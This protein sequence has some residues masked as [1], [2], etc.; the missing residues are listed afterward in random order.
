MKG[1]PCRAVL[2]GLLCCESK[3]APSSEPVNMPTGDAVTVL[4]P[5][6]T[7]ANGTRLDSDSTAGTAV[8][9][10]D[11]GDIIHAA[12]GDMMPRAAEDDS[13][14]FALDKIVEVHHAGMTRSARCSN[15]EP[16]GEEGKGRG[17]RKEL[18]KAH[19]VHGVWP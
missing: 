2:C 18:L 3:Y 14:P 7:Y 9:H 16:L 8:I 4:L 6:G 12:E 13:P 5:D 11:S 17:A 15:L 19:W 1:T 10:L